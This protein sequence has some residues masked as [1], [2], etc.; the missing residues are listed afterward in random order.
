MKQLIKGT[1]P[2]LFTSTLAMADWQPIPVYKASAIFVVKPTKVSA[3]KAAINKIIAPTRQEKGCLSYEAYQVVDS[4]GTP[5][6]RFEFHEI[7]TSEQAMMVDHK[8]KARHMVKFFKEIKLNEPESYV[9]TF[10]VK[11][12]STIK[13]E[14]Q[15]DL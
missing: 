2:I 10:E 3:F 7:W 1:F 15:N 13:I 8:E 11:G 5:T 12:H 14:A 9:E 4:S 6:N